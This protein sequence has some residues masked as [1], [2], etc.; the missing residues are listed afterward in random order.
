MKAREK[1]TRGGLSLILLASR[2]PHGQ[3]QRMACAWPS[4]AHNGSLFV[5][6][7]SIKSSTQRNGAAAHDASLAFSHR[8]KARALAGPSVASTH[9]TAR[10]FRWSKHTAPLLPDASPTRNRWRPRSLPRV[11]TRW[12]RRHHVATAPLRERTRAQVT[13]PSGP[14]TTWA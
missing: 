2:T 9:R 11:V 1:K 4:Q 6:R 5:Q 8:Q 7:S 10:S 13:R 14:A 12:P 3:T